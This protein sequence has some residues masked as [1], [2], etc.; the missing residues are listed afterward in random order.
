MSKKIDESPKAPFS[1]RF[2]A[3]W[4][5]GVDEAPSGLE[6]SQAMRSHLEGMAQHAGDIQRAAVRDGAR[7][8]GGALESATKLVS[9]VEYLETALVR[10]E[11]EYGKVLQAV[12]AELADLRAH[13]EREV[14][15]AKA[16]E[17]AQSQPLPTALPGQGIAAAA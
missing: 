2:R 5:R 9:Y 16:A 17:Q 10:T 7:I 11:T 6:L 15:A 1:E 3:W 14:E 13:L 12:R 8:R 4:F